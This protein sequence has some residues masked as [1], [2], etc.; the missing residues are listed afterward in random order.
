MATTERTT[1][2]G[3]K[4]RFLSR[5]QTPQTERV[6]L[7]RP[8]APFQQEVDL[9]PEISDIS[10]SMINTYCRFDATEKLQGGLVVDAYS[11][12]PE[13]LA[14]IMPIPIEEA[15]DNLR[16]DVKRIDKIG[17]D[18]LPP[19]WSL[20]RS[21]AQA[22]VTYKE[23]EERIA[24]GE[25]KTDYKEYLPKVSGFDP[26]LIS[27]KALD[28]GRERII[29][30]LQSKRLKFDPSKPQSVRAAFFAYQRYARRYYYAQEVAYRFAQ[31]DDQYRSK[32]GAVLEEDLSDV[33]YKIV[34]DQ[35]D[36]FWMMW[37]RPGIVDNILYANWHEKRHQKN[38]D[39]GKIQMF[40]FHEPPHFI[41]AYLIRRE[42][43][44][45]NL[46]PATGI[47]PIP[48]LGSYQYEGIAQT[49]PNFAPIELDSDGILATDV[50]RLEKRAINNGLYIL[51]TDS[52][53]TVGEVAREL[54]PYMLL[55][56]QSE[57]M[58]LLQEGISQPFE[59]AYL[60]VYGLSDYFFMDFAK[61]ANQIQRNEF[62]KLVFKKPMTPFQLQVAADEVLKVA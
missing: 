31:Y 60:P 41:Y 35:A 18:N 28:E 38:W 29:E 21:N 54:R 49:I 26:R 56:N 11:V 1:P 59:R 16:R 3:V 42:I 58:T 39:E 32:L 48:S 8:Q 33:N 13:D 20:I 44:K 40:A 23:E 47:L 50:Y 22:T 4:P 57:I 7:V 45:G 62:L 6:R 12:G 9:S 15:L 19:E 24:R 5:K 61:K 27:T 25:P 10:R 46:D 2:G 14:L 52:R 51:E 55:K 43:L 30:G 37:E 53:L 36:A 34:W 17:L